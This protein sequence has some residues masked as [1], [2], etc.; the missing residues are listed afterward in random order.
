[1]ANKARAKD[2]HATAA[3]RTNYGPG[4]SV[5]PALDQVIP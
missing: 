2:T 4:R 1:V 5:G 3:S